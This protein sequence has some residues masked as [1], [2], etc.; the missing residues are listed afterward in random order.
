MENIGETDLPWR[1]FYR[2]LPDDA[3]P[4]PWDDD[5]PERFGAEIVDGDGLR[6]GYTMHQLRDGDDG[7]HLLLRTL[8]PEAAPSWLVERHLWH[9]SIEFFNWTRVAWRESRA[10][11]QS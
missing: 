7:L 6:V 8:L 2:T 3:Y 5:Y 4:L 10:G 9:F 1:V 11:S